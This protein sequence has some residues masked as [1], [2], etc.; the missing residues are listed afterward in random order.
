[1]PNRLQYSFADTERYQ[2]DVAASQDALDAR[3][4][5]LKLDAVLVTSQDRYIS[6][7]TPIQN[8]PRYALTQFD[9]S[10]G[11]GVFL[12]REVADKLGLPAR[13]VLFV[14]G[15]Y[16]LQADQQT[17]PEQVVVEKLPLGVT[18]WG[19][20][21]DWLQARRPA[22]ARLGFDAQRTSVAQRSSLATQLANSK[23]DWVSLEHAEIDRAINLPGWHVERPIRRIPVSAT[24]RSVAD[25]FQRLGEMAAARHGVAKTCFVSGAADDLS[26]LL[27][28]R[29]YHLPFQSSQLGYLFAIGSQVALFLPEGCERCEVEEDPASPLK[30]FRNDYAGLITFLQGFDVA[31]VCYQGSRVNC[32]LAALTRQAWPQAAHDAECEAVE[33]MRTAKTEAELNAIRDAF[34]RSS[35]AIAATM[36]WTKY[37]EAGKPN[38]EHDLAARISAEYQ[39]Q[40]ALGLSFN[41]IAASDEMGAIMHYGK[42]SPQ[43]QLKEG[44]LILLDSGAYYEAGFATDCTRTVL[45]STGKDTRPQAW[46][47]EIYTVVL[48]ACVQ[49]MMARLPGSTTGHEVDKLVRD[50]V[51]AHGYDFAHGTGHGVGIHVHEEGIRFRPAIGYTLTPNA[52]ASIEPGIYLNG[53][54]GVRLEN[55]VIVRP[56]PEAQDLRYFENVVFVGYDWDLIDLALLSEEEKRYLADYEREC[57]ARGN[58]VT[59]CPLLG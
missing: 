33:S 18:I 25:N 22:I 39:A 3:L 4:A 2:A 8:N 53:Q 20:I 49:G 51:K 59:P 19:A 54:G 5:E 48:K 55:V 37:G 14:D 35:R 26:Y 6:E 32:A 12:R 21:S 17:K 50:V 7:Y 31:L 43:R 36:R 13:F 23:F 58:A 24:G 16:H 45:R 42:A 34:A 57:Q 56:Q 11:D 28:S 1:M 27:N 9:G 15:R 46:Q 38:S 41:T 44:E 52:V 29:G 47:K 30:V 40:G 10:M